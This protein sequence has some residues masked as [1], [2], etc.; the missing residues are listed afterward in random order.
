MVK[1][2]L[3]FYHSFLDREISSLN[4][5]ALL[6]GVFSLLSQF[7]GLLRDRLLANIFGASTELDIYYAAFRIPDFLFVTIASIVSL[8]VLVPFILEKDSVGRETL[9]KF[10]NT[11]FTFFSLLMALSAVVVYIFMPEL[12]GLLFKGFEPQ[13]LERIILIS[14][15]LLLSPI[16]L[17]LSNLMGSLTQAYNR[18]VVYAFAPVLYNSGIIVGIWLFTAEWGILG[19]VVGVVLG[20]LL[21]LLIQLPTVSK[22]GLMPRITLRP[23]WREIFKVARISL[24]RTLTLSMSSIV[25]IILTAMAAGLTAGSVSI[26]NFANN[27]QTMSLSLIGVSYSLAAFPTLTRKFQE[28][29]IGAFIEQMQ[30]SSRF[31]IFW[32]LP[33]TALL[34]VLRAQVVR[35]LLGSGLFDWEATRL[36]AAALAIFVFSSLFQSMLL[37]WMRGFYSAGHTKKPFFINLISTVILIVMTFGLVWTFDHSSIF[38]YFILALLKVGDLSFNNA[39]MLMLPLGFTL[40][41]ILNGLLLWLAFELQFRGYSRGVLRALFQGVCAAVILGAVTYWGL[42]FFDNVFNLNTLL[43]IFFQGLSAGVLGILAGILVLSLLKSAELASVFDTL[44]SKF[45]KTKIIATDPEIV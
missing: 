27:L 10:L 21:H 17:G 1:K 5:A 26:L 12:S 42:D 35:T 7:V 44:R 9:R 31:I 6:L 22:A 14:R 37:L 23:D 40:G 15:I 11:V 16:I 3:S 41:T 25:F 13:V 8:S 24:P 20:A 2:I 33:L 18:F 28:K 29:N 36:T 4:K 32:S 43:G 34:I 45:W 30:I 39:K 38:S 19:P